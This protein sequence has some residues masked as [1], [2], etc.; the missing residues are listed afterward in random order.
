MQTTCFKKFLCG[1]TKVGPLGDIVFWLA[2]MYDSLFS[3][4]AM[5]DAVNKSNIGISST[6]FIRFFYF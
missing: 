2:L 6:S 1:P 4:K 5:V 3:P